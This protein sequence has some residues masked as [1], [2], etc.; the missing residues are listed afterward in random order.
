MMRGRW[1]V[2]IGAAALLLAPAACGAHRAGMR[3]EPGKWE[4]RTSSNQ[5]MG[6]NKERVTTRCLSENEM[7]PDIFRERAPK[8]GTARCSVT[9]PAFVTLHRF[10]PRAILNGSSGVSPTS[11]HSSCDDAS[12]RPIP[13]SRRGFGGFYWGLWLH[14][15]PRR[16]ASKCLGLGDWRHRPPAYRGLVTALDSGVHQVSEEPEESPAPPPTLTTGCSVIGD[17]GSISAG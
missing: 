6:D 1:W 11:D 10:K 9:K 7:K 16:V 8:N 14:G 4:F 15:S 2:V 12:A 5:P 13:H 17:A 3:V